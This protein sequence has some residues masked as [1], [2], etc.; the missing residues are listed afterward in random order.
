MVYDVTYNN[1][2]QPNMGAGGQGP[3]PSPGESM[4]NV[5]VPRS[6]GDVELGSLQEALA[7]NLGYFVEIDFLIGTNN[8]VT[9]SGILYAV[10]V[11]YVTLYQEED[12]RYVVCDMYSIKF[13]AFYNSKVTPRNRGGT[14]NRSG[15][16]GMNPGMGPMF[17]GPRNMV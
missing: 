16:G 10:G 7:D 6:L 11:N 17:N 13:V 1:P 2:I 14:N 3:D 4:E 15:M 9:R 5:L 12:D 8:I